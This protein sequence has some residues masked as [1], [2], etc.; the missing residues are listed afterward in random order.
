MGAFVMS[1][2]MGCPDKPVST[3]SD[4]LFEVSS[5]V[6]GLC[7]FVRS[8]DTPMTISI[9]GDWGSG[10]TSMMNMMRENLEAS[11]WPIWFNTWQFSQFNMGNSLVFSMMDVLLNGLGCDKTA[12]VKILGGI[13]KNVARVVIDKTA[14]GVVEE[15]ASDVMNGESSDF[16]SEVLELKKKFQDAV[17]KKLAKEHRDRVVV[18]VDDLDRLHPLKAIELL[19]VLKLFLDCDKC[20]F[21]LAVDYEVVTLGIKEKFGDNVSEEK[22]RS[23]FDKIIQLPFKMPVAQYDISKYVKEMMVKMSITPTGY[24]ISLYTN[25]IKTSVGY[26]PRSMKR[27]FNTYQLLDIISNTATTTKIDDVVKKRVLFATV[28]AQMNF[29]EFY[30]YL[31]ATRLDTDTFTTLMDSSDD[32]S[33]LNDLYLNDNAETKEKKIRKLSLFLPYFISALRSGETEELTED[34]INALNI[35]LKCSVVTSV[36]AVSDEEKND[37]KWDHRYRNKD[38][39]KKT[40]GLLADIGNF[41][42][43]MSRTEHGDVKLY[44]ISGYYK[45]DILN[46]L[47]ITLEYYVTRKDESHIAVHLYITNQN[48]TL[49]KEF[50]NALGDNP[51]KMTSKPVIEEWGRYKYMNIL[52]LSDTDTH[53]SE[54]IAS[55]VRNAYAALTELKP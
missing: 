55:V 41:S 44:D 10:K 36:N 2:E 21:I 40:A 43:W 15:I 49:R 28:C 50:F 4:D 6:D 39:V 54:Q 29:E 33:A 22:G 19:E 27:L 5:Y 11:I 7:S 34:D 38:I 13:A 37:L 42:M 18:F 35:I 46:G 1:K 24:D 23:F 12:I 47:D 3:I 20:V 9:Q 30:L 51:L 48:K 25:L 8:C 31:T 53:S 16:A 32:N 45:F 52:S 26:N 17:N 14:G